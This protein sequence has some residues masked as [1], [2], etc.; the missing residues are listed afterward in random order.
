[1]LD[2]FVKLGEVISKGM[3]IIIRRQLQIE[4]VSTIF[5][6]FVPVRSWQ[7][8]EIFLLGQSMH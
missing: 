7:M 6:N 4:K 1:M 5:E 8:S 3:A 2:V